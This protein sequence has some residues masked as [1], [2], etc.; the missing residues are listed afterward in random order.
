MGRPKV[1]DLFESYGNFVTRR[2]YAVLAGSLL[3]FVLFGSGLMKLETT[4]EAVKLWAIRER[5]YDAYKYMDEC[6]G[7]TPS[8]MTV[9]C[10]RVGAG[11]I[12]DRVAVLEMLKVHNWTTQVLSVSGGGQQ[13]NFDYFC[14]KLPNETECVSNKP[15]NS[16]LGTWNFDPANVPPTEALILQQLT[17]RHQQQNVAAFSAE[18][19]FSTVGGVESVVS[20]RAIRMRYL[21]DRDDSNEWG[22]E[23]EKQWNDVDSGVSK[24]ADASIIRVTH[25][26]AAG[27]DQ[28]TARLVSEDIPLFACAIILVTVFLS[29]TLG[30]TRRIAK[31]SL[32]QIPDLVRT[33]QPAALQPCN[34]NLQPA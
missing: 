8:F 13:R 9:Y 4:S 24:S 31:C 26:S 10:E 6:C 18:P 1:S 30:R 20:S 7:S 12:F 15:Q 33:L 27:I 19:V 3:V 21:I 5:G 29:L 17:A 2:P 11:S 28:E 34:P 14:S 23:F 16:L 32:L 25:Y 22:E